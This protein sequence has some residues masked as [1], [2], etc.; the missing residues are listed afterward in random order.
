MKVKE[1]MTSDVKYCR[2]EESLATAAHLMW[3]NDCGA[4]PVVDSNGKVQGMIT[5]RDICIAAATRHRLASDIAIQEVISGAVYAC[6]PGDDLKTA[7]KT[8]QEK[9][10]HRLPVINQ[11]GGLEGI[12]CLNDLILGSEKSA[13]AEVPYGLIMETLK[14]VGRH[15]E[16]TSQPHQLSTL[17]V[18]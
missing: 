3:E 13:A 7:L 12:L 15:R 6:L 5:D 14:A 8:M 17:V 11:A 10:V 4:I 9:R 2:P 1:F 18:A 16:I